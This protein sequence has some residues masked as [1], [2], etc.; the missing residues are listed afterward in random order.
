LYPT[1][2]FLRRK[3]LIRA[4]VQA[5]FHLYQRNTRLE[6]LALLLLYP[7]GQEQ[8]W[9]ELMIDDFNIGD[10]AKS[11]MYMCARSPTL[12]GGTDMF[13]KLLSRMGILALAAIGLL[14]VAGPAK[15][16]QGWPLQG[17][18]WSYHFGAS[19]SSSGGNYSRSYSSPSYSSPT[20]YSR[21]YYSPSYYAV[22]PSSFGSYRSYYY[23]SSGAGDYY[24]TSTAESPQ[25][26]PARINLQ[27]PSDAKIWFDDS[28][29]NQT[30]ASRSFE[31]PPLPADRDYSYQVR[32][33]WKQDGKDVS[34]DRKIIVHSGDVINLTLGSPP[35]V[36]VAR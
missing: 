7:R 28:Q 32:I 31:S 4:S 3:L 17:S 11:I 12:K 6:K 13:R 9:F 30:G 33:Q 22:S 1:G 18:N 16:Q 35:G 27:V 23:G 2:S 24:I 36:A 21:S 14:L 20:Y 5:L 19:Q 25:K 29:T 8:R 34:E 10:R 15:A 26:R